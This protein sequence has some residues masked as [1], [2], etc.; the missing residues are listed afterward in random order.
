MAAT[1]NPGDPIGA[2]AIAHVEPD[3]ITVR[4]RDL[5]RDLIGQ[6][7]LTSYFL[8]L[9]TGNTPDARLVAIT[10]ACMVALAEHGLVPSVQAARMTHAAAPD[11]LQGAVAAGI[12]GCGSVIL[13]ASETAARMLHAVL[14]DAD[15][16]GISLE[17]AAAAH[18]AAL[19]AGRQPLPGYGHPVHRQED[20]RATRLLAYA[21]E[22]QVSGR[23]VQALR[24]IDAQVA[25]VYGRRLPM[26]VSAAIPAVL[27]D[28][29][30][31]LDAMKGVSMVART[32][33]LVAHL[34]EEKSRPIGF[35]LAAHAESGIAYD[36][37]ESQA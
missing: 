29:G 6:S 1:G 37:P 32:T 22:L 23:H 15:A 36:G 10:D 24:A 35:R 14:E 26:N 28:A 3:R 2:S 30:F 34:L 21:D 4:G 16:Q 19:K 27:L 18:L 8:F 5:C 11:A 33:S 17:A 20:P 12:L 13:G 25:Q 7:S 9:L 31:P